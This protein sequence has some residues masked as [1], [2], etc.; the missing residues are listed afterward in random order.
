M[1][2]IFSIVSYF[3]AHCLRGGETDNGNMLHN[4]EQPHI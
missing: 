2:I 1:R 4:H 3:F